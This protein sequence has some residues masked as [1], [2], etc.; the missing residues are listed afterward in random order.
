MEG[1]CVCRQGWR[2]PT[3]AIVD[4]EARQ[5]LP[6]CSGHGDFDL[7]TQKCV[8]RG[9]WTGND[10]SKGKLFPLSRIDMAYVMASFGLFW[11][12]MKQTLSEKMVV[13]F[14]LETFFSSPLCS[15]FFSRSQHN[16]D[17][18]VRQT[19][20]TSSS[21]PTK[22]ANLHHFKKLPEFSL[23]PKKSSFA[24][25]PAFTNSEK[26]FVYLQN[27]A[28]WTAGLMDLANQVDVFVRLAGKVMFAQSKLVTQDALLMACAPMGRA[29]VLMVSSLLKMVQGEFSRG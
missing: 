2:G 25:V 28:I 14:C 27:G 29:C 7:E 22:L 20:L 11:P 19:Q 16:I 6:D 18:L 15:N 3:C 13:V 9:Q 10:C 23:F 8:C 12:Q 4:K 24:G 17:T 21:L 26:K 1:S 5:C